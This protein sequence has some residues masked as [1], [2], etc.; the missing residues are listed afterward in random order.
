MSNNAAR[1][2]KANARMSWSEAQQTRLGI[3]KDILDHEFTGVSWLNTT[4]AGNTQ[5]E[6]KSITNNGKNY[7][8]RIYIPKNFPGDCPILVVS[9][10]PYGSP[11]KTKYGSP[12]T[13]GSSQN[14]TYTAY[15][16]FTRICHFKEC[17]WSDDNTL[18]QVFM[19]GRL[20]LEAYECHRESGA[21]LERYLPHMT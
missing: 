11:L 15:E 19:K 21:N 4:S 8:L 2:V 16:G 20:W 14:H 17:H 5:V 7:T 6:W 3:E 12:L 13:E 18:S 10:S 1:E 9:K